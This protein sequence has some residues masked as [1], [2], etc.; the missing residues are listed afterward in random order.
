MTVGIPQALSYHYYGSFWQ[1][2]LRD[3]GVDVMMSGLT[4]RKKLDDGIKVTP[5]EACLPLKCY[6]GHVLSLIGKV[7]HIFV[8]RLLCLQADPS[9]RLGCPKLIGLP[10][11]VQALTPEAN[12]LTMDIDLRTESEKRS[13]VRMAQGL[14]FSEHT[15]QHAYCRSIEASA[16]TKD[17]TSGRAYTNPNTN[18]KFQI[19]LLGHAYLLNDDYLNLNLMTK[20]LDTG[21][22]V[23]NCHELPEDAII[24]AA[25]KIN[26]LSWYFET[27]ILS[28]AHVFQNSAEVSGIIYLL[29]FGCG[30]GSITHEVIDL[31]LRTEQTIPFLKIVLDEHTGETGLMT[32][33]ESFLDMIKLRKERKF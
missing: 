3:L 4:D 12:V 1:D 15:A 7:D 10:D 5:S 20:I 2:Y 29:S 23:I 25:R 24:R 27:H 17:N 31:E 32:R 6:V 19:G 11:M 28:A 13:Y 26:P 30:A 33:I 18:G 8:P 9:I 22:H 14:G 21:V 16:Q